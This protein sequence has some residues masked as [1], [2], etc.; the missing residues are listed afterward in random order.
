MNGLCY[1]YNVYT[2]QICI[3]IRKPTRL[4]SLICWS[5]ICM[6]LKSKIYIQQ[7]KLS[8]TE[9]PL[10][11]SVWGNY[12]K[13]W[14]ILFR[15]SASDHRLRISKRIHWTSEKMVVIG[16][17]NYNNNF[18][19]MNCIIMNHDL[20]YKI[21]FLDFSIFFRPSLVHRIV[22]HRIITFH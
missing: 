18:S 4:T 21:N 19:K 10:A 2:K 5:M 9:R 22:I 16:S 1:K 13:S 7:Q 14:T 3:L 11:L 8:T 15:W 6:D 12:W 17:V 20:I